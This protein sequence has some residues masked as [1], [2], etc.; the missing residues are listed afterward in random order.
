MSELESNTEEKCSATIIATINCTNEALRNVNTILGKI[1]SMAQNVA[2]E[3]KSEKS[4]LS[5]SPDKIKKWRHLIKTCNLPEGA[6]I[7]LISRF[8]LMIRPCVLSLT[9]YAAIIGALFAVEKH[10][11]RDVNWFFFLIAWIGVLIAH[12][13]NNML[14][15][16]FDVLQG[17]DT[18]D[19]VRAQYAPHP[20]LQGF[21]SKRAQVTTIFVFLTINATIAL[22]FTWAVHWYVW[23]FALSGLFFSIGYV[24]PPLKFKHRGL[25]ELSNTIVWGPLMIGGV[26]YVMTGDY[27]WDVFLASWPYGMLV[28][29]MLVA[30]H[31]DKYPEDKEKGI[32]TLPVIIGDRASRILLKIMVVL[33]PVYIIGLAI[34]GVLGWWVVLVVLSAKRLIFVFKQFSL[35]RPSE[36]PEDFP[37]WPLWYIAFG[38]HYTRLVAPLFFLG[39]ILNVLIPIPEVLNL[40]GF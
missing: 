24:A 22:F 9:S 8:L 19:Y 6:E 17:I 10:G 13:T 32:N 28:G 5:E 3:K 39:L 26:Y 11:Y 4:A 16:L 27:S 29:M 14:N 40:I 31:L 20:L 36:P 33:V 37:V 21:V 15:D 25:G 30:K 34:L 38:F 1:H 23:I 12:A 2:G 18:V 35:P 7:D